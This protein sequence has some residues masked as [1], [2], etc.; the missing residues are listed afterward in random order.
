MTPLAPLIPTTILSNQSSFPV[1][2][3]W[4]PLIRNL[5]ET[6]SFCVILPIASRRIPRAAGSP[7]QI[8]FSSPV[9]W[10][11]SCEEAYR[12]LQNTIGFQK[13][14][15]FK[16]IRRTQSAHRYWLYGEHHEKYLTWFIRISKGTRNLYR[17]LQRPTL[18]TKHSGECHNTSQA[19][20][21]YESIRLAY[22]IIAVK[23][24]LTLWL[25]Q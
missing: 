5:F 17:C 2:S 8:L 16:P 1:F 13:A 23:P 14:L 15:L 21:N 20:K 10:P 3:G 12:L 24:L 6:K 22:S 18:I 9:T 4:R 11:L 25:Q 19:I 7:P